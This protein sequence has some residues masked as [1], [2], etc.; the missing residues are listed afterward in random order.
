MMELDNFHLEEVNKDDNYHQKIIKELNS[1]P[2]VKKH[3]GS[4]N[5]SIDFTERN[6][7]K[8]GID[9]IY[10]AFYNNEAI[11]MISLNAVD[12][13]YEISYAILSEY[14]NGYLAS[15]LLQEFSEK[16][17]ENYSYINQLNLLILNI[18]TASKKVAQLVG[19]KKEENSNYYTMKR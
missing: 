16:V 13:I 19:Y 6:A 4:M 2:M 3:L 12:N 18:N 1:D 15:L 11:G 8:T 7:L 10:I 9:V 5:I 17:F 14:R